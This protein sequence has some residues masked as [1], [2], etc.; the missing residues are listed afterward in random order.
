MIVI[1]QGR[2]INKKNGLLIGLIA[3]LPIVVLLFVRNRYSFCWSD[4]SFYI[5]LVHR[6]YLNG[7]PFIDEWNPA[8]FYSVLFVPLYYIY[9]NWGGGTKASICLQGTF[10][11]YLLFCRLIMYFIFLGPSLS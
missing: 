5:A 11:Y 9:A 2:Y 10:M 6:L 1:N 4:E 8:Q 7:K 3:L